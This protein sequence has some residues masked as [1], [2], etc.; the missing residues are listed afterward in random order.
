[1]CAV[2]WGSLSTSRCLLSPLLHRMI[3]CAPVS[4]AVITLVMLVIIEIIVVF[5]VTVLLHL[6]ALL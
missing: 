6:L 3:S 5:I 1:M 4:A 2:L